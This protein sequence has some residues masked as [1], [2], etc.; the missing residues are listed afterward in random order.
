M[1]KYAIGLDYGT[2][3]ARAVLVDVS[4]GNELASAAM[5]YPHRVMDRSLPCGVPLG[6]D[7]A[8]QHPQDYLD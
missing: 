5:D 7:W 2:L 4:N 3:S 1:S 6:H 8:L